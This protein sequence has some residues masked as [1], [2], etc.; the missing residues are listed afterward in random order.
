MTF[1]T[2]RQVIWSNR[3]TGPS[4]KATEEV[5]QVGLETVEL[6]WVLRIEQILS[7]AISHGKTQLSRVCTSNSYR[8]HCHTW[9]TAILHC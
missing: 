6:I 8:Q 5:C 4:C 7:A 9:G 1:M 2:V 3:D